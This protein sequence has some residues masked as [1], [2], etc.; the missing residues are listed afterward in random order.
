MILTPHDP[1]WADE[2]AALRHVFTAVLG[3][4]ILRVEHVGSTA[5]PGLQAKPIL[6]IDIVMAD[7]EVFPKIIEGLGRLGYQYNGDQGIRHREAFNPQDRE[8][9][10]TLPRR[11]WNQHHLYVCPTGSAEL[12]RHIV[13]REVLRARADLREEYEKV[14]LSIANRSGGN[15]KN[16]AQ[17]KETECRAFVELVLNERPNQFVQPTP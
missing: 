5:V 11:Q 16:Y 12:H 6:D 2:F 8:V 15:R 4:L 10:Y 9:P 13:F 17:I 3:D 1:V 14:K 7:Y